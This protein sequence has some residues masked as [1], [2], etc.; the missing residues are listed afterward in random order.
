S[1]YTRVMG[2]EDEGR[3]NGPAPASVP[4]PPPTY[5]QSANAPQQP[6]G[7]A[8]PPQQQVHLPGQPQPFYGQQQPPQVLPG[9]PM[10]YASYQPAMGAAPI[11]IQPGAPQLQVRWVAVPA[12]IPGCPPGLEF[13][14]GL[15]KIII[16]QKQE[17]I[18]IVTAI[19]IPNRYSIETPTGEQIYFAAEDADFVQA[20]V[21]GADRGYRIKVFDGYNRVAFTIA[22]P[23][24][25]CKCGCCACCDG[26]KRHSTIE[27]AG[28]IFGAM[29][30][31][32]ACCASSL[33]I[34]DEHDK[35]VI[36]ID[37][38]CCC[39]RCCSDADFPL[40]SAV[41][42]S[43]LGQITRK[44][45]GYIHSNYS[46]ADVFEIE[47]PSDLSVRMKAA[48]IGSCI[49][50]DFLEFEYNNNRNNT[51]HNHN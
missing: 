2:T 30:T 35:D 34:T 7:Y 42:G 22:R 41:N 12:S 6:Y 27:G 11:V 49:M 16:R 14:D 4:E 50:I 32:R 24:Q 43:I 37:G 39:S 48:V 36:T 28:E 8:H 21:M 44:Y 3:P 38:P 51:R 20:Q 10:P 25:Y 23:L 5:D 33:T 45:L 9:Q 26:C 17:L 19:E 46:K 40:K 15:N 13:L 29:R 1:L 18:E 47:F 31:R